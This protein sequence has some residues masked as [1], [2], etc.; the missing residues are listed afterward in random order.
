MTL[1]AI[2]YPNVITAVTVWDGD[3]S[4]N[5]DSLRINPI[6]SIYKGNWEFRK[7]GSTNK[8]TYRVYYYE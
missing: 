2:E 7:N 1:S 5:I 3:K 8:F 6:I 4:N